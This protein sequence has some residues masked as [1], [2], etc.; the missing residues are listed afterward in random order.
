MCRLTCN[1]FLGVVIASANDDSFLTRF[2]AR[3]NHLSRVN[4][5]SSRKDHMRVVLILLI[6]LSSCC[7]CVPLPCNAQV[8]TAANAAPTRSPQSSSSPSSKGE[9]PVQSRDDLPRAL[10]G[11]PIYISQPEFYL[12]LIIAALGLATLIM[13]YALLRKNPKLKTEEALRIFGV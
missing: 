10:Y 1:Q 12:S 13:E 3:F 6:A 11:G 7:W 8:T 9:E 2:F 4:L 5:V